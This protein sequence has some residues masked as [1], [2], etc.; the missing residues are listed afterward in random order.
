MIE[1]AGFT[2]GKAHCAIEAKPPVQWNKGRASIYILRTAFGVDWSE[3]IRIIYVG[4]DATDEDAMQVSN[5]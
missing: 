4:D 1:D 5:L 2:V 3:R